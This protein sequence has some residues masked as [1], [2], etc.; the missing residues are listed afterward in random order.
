L[1]CSVIKIR[2][3]KSVK[4]SNLN[5]WSGGSKVD[6]NVEVAPVVVFSQPK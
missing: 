5:G 2:I 1:E 3:L 6:V 4:E